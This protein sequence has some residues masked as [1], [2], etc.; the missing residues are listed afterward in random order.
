LRSATWFWVTHDLERAGSGA[1]LTLALRAVAKIDL[2]FTLPASFWHRWI[3]LE[4]N[5]IGH[6]NRRDIS[7]NAVGIP[8][9]KI[10]GVP[11]VELDVKQFSLPITDLRYVVL[12]DRTHGGPAGGRE[13]PLARRGLGIYLGPREAFSRSVNEHLRRYLQDS[14][15]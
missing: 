7:F 12:P 11:L 5:A 1:N 8:D 9:T 6:E 3:V 4:R 13:C 2:V 15:G 14:F 10:L